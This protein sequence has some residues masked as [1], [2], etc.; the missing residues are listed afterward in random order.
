MAEGREE[1]RLTTI[2]AADVVGYSGLVEADEAGTLAA[3]CCMDERVGAKSNCQHCAMSQLLPVDALSPTQVSTDSPIGTFIFVISPQ[4]VLYKELRYWDEDRDWFLPNFADG[5][6]DC[7]H[8]PYPTF[9]H[10]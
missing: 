2:M 10:G 9:R 4:V 6:L 7:F 8:L 1:R 5:K 3:H